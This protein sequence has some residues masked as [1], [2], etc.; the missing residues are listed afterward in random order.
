[1]NKPCSSLAPQVAK[2]SPDMLPF[3]DTWDKKMAEVNLFVEQHKASDSSSSSSSSSS[4]SSDDD[5]DDS[6]R[7]LRTCGVCQASPPEG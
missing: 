7:G 3:L 1:M 2:K 6:R 4:E 5:D